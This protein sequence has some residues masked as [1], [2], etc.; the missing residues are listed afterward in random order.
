MFFLVGESN[1]RPQA[2]KVKG[3]KCFPFTRVMS[4]RKTETSFRTSD[5]LAFN[6]LV[7]LIILKLRRCLCNLKYKCLLL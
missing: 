1:H 3:G 6:P 7:V 5:E 4:L 2:I